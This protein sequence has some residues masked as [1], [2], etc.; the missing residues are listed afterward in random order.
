MA[1]VIMFTVDIAGPPSNNDD[2]F[3]RDFH[4]NKHQKAWVQ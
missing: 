1:K 4:N 3:N 2:C